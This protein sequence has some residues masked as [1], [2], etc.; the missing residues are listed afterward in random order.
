M[1]PIKKMKC[2]T[3][4]STK[5]GLFL[6]E[7]VTVEAAEEIGTEECQA[8]VDRNGN[9]SEWGDNDPILVNIADLSRETLD[10]MPIEVVTCNGKCEDEAFISIDFEDGK[11]FS[12]N[13]PES[14][15]EAFKYFLS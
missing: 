5:G 10:A 7:L 6:T 4:G 3:C 15:T 14:E 8:I 13:D 11:S 2:N 9:V 1:K 12:V